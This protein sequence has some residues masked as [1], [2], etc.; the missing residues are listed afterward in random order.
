[1]SKRGALCAR[2]L[3]VAFGKWLTKDNLLVHNL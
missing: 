2:P 3:I 1:M